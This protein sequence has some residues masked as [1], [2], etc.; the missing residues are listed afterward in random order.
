M[1]IVFGPVP[2]RRLGRSLGVNN[3]PPKHCTYSC[4][5][6]QLGRTDHLT[7]S[8]RKFYDWD[9]IVREVVNKASKVGL[10]NIDYVTF[11]PDGEPTL[12]AFLGKE[13]RE[14]KKRLPVRVAV[15]TN[16]SLLWMDDVRSDLQEADWVSVK[17]DAVTEDAYRR[18]DRPHP[19]LRLPAV[20]GGIEEFS[21]AYH[22][23]LVTETMLVAGVN[24]SV[25]ELEETAKFIEELNPAKA[26]IA[27][28]IRP[29]AEAWAVPPSEKVVLSAYQIFEEHLGDRVELLI[30]AEGGDFVIDPDKPVES[31]LGI[32]S[33]HPIRK[34]VLIRL[35]EDKGL[36]PEEVVD[37]ITRSGE[38][39][40]V[41]FEGEEFLVRRLPGRKDLSNRRN[42]L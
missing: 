38:A 7:V 18:V 15:I 30:G 8:R 40:L 36:D 20:L 27:V 13:I 39:V 32:I 1:D 6:C 23:I 11:V 5:Y 24:D 35:L 37:R 41:E 2:S 22:G 17:V 16:G 29:P 26:Y 19:S 34:N 10:S 33:V 9:F 28:P 25:S 14:I 42:G 3:I 31:I 4:I 12:D 21:R